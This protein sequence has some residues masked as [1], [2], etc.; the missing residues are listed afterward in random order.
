MKYQLYIDYFEHLAEQHKAI[1]HNEDGKCHFSSLP[2]DAQNKF[3]R[4]MYYPCVTLALGDEQWNDVGELR[5]RT[6]VSLFFVDHVRDTGDYALVQQTL[7]AMGRV[8]HDFARRMLRD[9]GR[10]TEA[11]KRLGMDNA[12][13]VQVYM[14]DAAL[15]GW[16]LTFDLTGNFPTIDCYDSFLDHQ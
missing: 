15:Y 6:E 1:R 9:H 13:A 10:G 4:K 7:N 3:A 2:E 5:Q 8:M 11:V 12:Q 16:V 14:A